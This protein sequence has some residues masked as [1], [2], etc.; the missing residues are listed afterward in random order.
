ARVAMLEV[1]RGNQPAIA[2]YRSL[3]YREVGVRPR[4]YA[5]DGEDALVMDKDL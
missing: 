3:G 5:E 2:L 1:R 4:Y